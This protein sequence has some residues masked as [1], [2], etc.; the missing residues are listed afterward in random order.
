M[1]PEILDRQTLPPDLKDK[2][3]GKRRFEEINAFEKHLVNNGTLAL[4]FFLSVSKEEQ[5]RRF[6]ARLDC[7]RRIGNFPAPI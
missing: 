5:R 7:R 1:H 4:K 6:L 3:V 2:K